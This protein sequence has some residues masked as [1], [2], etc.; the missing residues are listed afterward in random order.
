MYCSLS[1]SPRLKTSTPFK[2]TCNLLYENNK[3]HIQEFTNNP[4]SDDGDSHMRWEVVK[5]D[6]GAI[7]QQLSQITQNNK[8]DPRPPPPPFFKFKGLNGHLRERK[9]YRMVPQI[10]NSKVK[11]TKPKKRRQKGSK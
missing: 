5:A 3:K 1:F 9:T 2:L 6:I 10:I 8:H 7:S 11:P 4:I